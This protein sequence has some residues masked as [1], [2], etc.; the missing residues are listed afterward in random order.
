MNSFLLISYFVL[1]IVVIAQFIAIMALA[2][3]LGRILLQMRPDI[4]A[5]AIND[6]PDV[7]EQLPVTV[8]TDYKDRRLSLIQSDVTKKTLLLFTSPTCPSCEDLYPA[9]KTLT[10]SEKDILDV[11]LISIIEVNG[12]EKRMASIFNNTQI[13]TV[14][15]PRFAEEMNITGT[16]YAILIDSEAFVRSKGIVN[17]IIHLESLINADRL[18]VATINEYY[19]RKNIEHNNGSADVGIL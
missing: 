18:G 11:I 1:W 2:H 3:Q 5:A 7:G 19:K 17:N 6:G 14:I 13:N 9:V 12:Y 15:S 16:P 10:R 8:I 4:G